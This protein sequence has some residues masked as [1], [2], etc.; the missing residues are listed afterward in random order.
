MRPGIIILEEREGVGASA[1]RGKPA[2]VNIRMFLPNG[3][4]LTELNRYGQRRIIDLRKRRVIAGIRYGIE[5][6]R[7][8][9]RRLLK[10]SP[11][12]AY[13]A[14]GV[15]GQIPPN[16]YIHCEI[17]LLEVRD[18]NKPRPEDY[19]PGKR[20]FVVHRG[21]LARCVPLWQFSLMEDGI[22]GIIVTVPI[23]GLKWRHARSKHLESKIDQ[24]R[25]ADIFDYA[26]EFPQRFPEECVQRPFNQG[27]DSGLYVDERKETF[28]VSVS[29]YERDKCI[30]QY[31]AI[32]NG[33]FWVASELHKTIDELLN[34]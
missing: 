10:I 27:G 16:A 28:C 8:G 34:L 20:L 21:E 5:G 26:M 24:T 12:L 33:H 31:N 25:A 32:E 11:H 13:G 18:D 17:E 29:I 3:A 23:P 19:P 30:C 1:V 14:K 22:C 7:V 15:H 9:G 6:M 2:I 4:D